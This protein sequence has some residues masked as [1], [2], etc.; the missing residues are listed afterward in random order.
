MDTTGQLFEAGFRESGRNL[1][2]N[3]FSYSLS[4]DFRTDL[5]F[6]RR[7]NQRRIFTF[8]TYRFWPESWIINWGPSLRYGLNWNFD[9][10]LDD[11][12][13]ST[14]INAT[15]ARNIE[16]NVDI[17]RDMERYQGINFEKRGYSVGGRV[18]T[19]R[20]LSV[21]GF[22]RYGDEIRYV[23]NPFLG[24]GGSGGLFITA[25]PV[26][27]FQSNIT[28][29]T[30]TLV[31]PRN[32]DELVFDVKIFR[33]L[34]TYQ[35]TDRLLFRNIAEYNTFDKTIGNNV[36]LT[37]RVN[38][39]TAFYIGYDDHYQQADRVFTDPDGDD[40]A[41]YQPFP[42]ITSMTQTN[43]SIFTKIQFLFRY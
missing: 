24:R 39:G 33:A 41:D 32:G 29:S 18:G 3:F 40:V 38:A 19:S 36:L 30:S 12:E 31:D 22:F 20:K 7:T 15:F 9:N 28:I 27:R 43:R 2:Y 35:F 23:E 13:T 8:A 6:V 17:R 37:Y 5:G 16:V 4:P 11:E 25:Q 42:G 21:G 10:I 1:S 26:S 34:S 14:G